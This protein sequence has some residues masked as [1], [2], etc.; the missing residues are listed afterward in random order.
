ML[1]STHSLRCQ[2]VNT[3]ILPDPDLF[4]L[5]ISL[6]GFLFGVLV[7]FSPQFCFTSRKLKGYLLNVTNKS[8]IS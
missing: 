8:Q 5:S 1:V 3:I 7:A 2:R 6:Y 4:C